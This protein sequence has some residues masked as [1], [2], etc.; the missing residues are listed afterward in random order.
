[1]SEV[2]VLLPEVYEAELPRVCGRIDKAFVLGEGI[3]RIAKS[4]REDTRCSG[5]GVGLQV[6]EDNLPMLE[7]EE[8]VQ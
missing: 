2:E 5:E 3:L 7:D 6:G 4:Q 8:Q 1:V